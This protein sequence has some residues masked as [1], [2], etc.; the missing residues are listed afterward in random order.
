MAREREIIFGRRF[1]RLAITLLEIF[2]IFLLLNEHSKG[3]KLPINPFWLGKYLLKAGY[4]A[5]YK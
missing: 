5:D 4:A 3:V 1:L 2:V